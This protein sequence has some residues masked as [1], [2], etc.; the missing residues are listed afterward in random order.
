[1]KLAL[2]VR[3]DRPAA[4]DLAE[5]VIAGAGSRGLEAVLAPDQL[6]AGTDVVVAIGGDGTM[7]EAV[8]RARP[9]DVPVLGINMGHVAYLAA[10]NPDEVDRA[11]DVLA[12]NEFDIV[13]R[14]TVAVE[15]DGGSDVGINDVV[16][17]KHDSQTSVR[18]SVAIDDQY[19]MTYRG[20][21][22]VVATATGST[23]Y[24]FSAGGPM[25]DPDIDA[26]VLTPVAAHNL[27]QKTVV[28]QPT[29]RLT[30]ELKAERLATLA[31]DGRNR[32]T[33]EPGQDVRVQA[34]DRRAKFV[35]PWPRPLHRVIQ[36]KWRLDDA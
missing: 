8:R 13:S 29:V 24:S 4:A 30:I 21:G 15:W 14:M 6:P 23:A 17:E 3:P 16:V 33:L 19:F 1:M 10:V 12:A 26:L 9:A 32:H 20:D 18:L 35:V 25:I 34:G 31:V 36:E 28:L 22:V 5:A 7:L 27:F 11:L 2:V